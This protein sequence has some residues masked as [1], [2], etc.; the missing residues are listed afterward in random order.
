M[1]FA[2]S[3]CAILAAA[4]LTTIGLVRGTATPNLE[5][6]I[7]KRATRKQYVS[8]TVASWVPNYVAAV[9]DSDGWKSRTHLESLPGFELTNKIDIPDNQLPKAIFKPVNMNFY[10]CSRRNKNS[11]KLA[12]AET[13]AGAMVPDHPYFFAKNENQVIF[14]YDRLFDVLQNGQPSWVHDVEF[15]GSIEH[16]VQHAKDNKDGFNIGRTHVGNEIASV[17]YALD[18]MHYLKEVRAYQGQIKYYDSKGL[19]GP[20]LVRMYKNYVCRIIERQKD[21]KQK[22]VPDDI[23]TLKFQALISEFLQ[24][25]EADKELQIIL[26]KN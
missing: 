7:M 14:V 9:Y 5:D 8:S 15:R 23:G 6:A 25:Q 10:E 19:L 4:S 17:F 16:E 22:G 2:A 20:G 24:E 26:S 3:L 11:D 21:C 1:R 18:F 13:D 12:Q